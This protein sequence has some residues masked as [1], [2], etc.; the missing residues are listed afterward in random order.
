MARTELPATRFAAPVGPARR[1]QFLQMQRE[2]ALAKAVPPGG[3][4]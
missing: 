2:S 1:V 4:L 3:P